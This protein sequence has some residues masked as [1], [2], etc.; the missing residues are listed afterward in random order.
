MILVL[1]TRRVE[2]AG[3]DVQMSIAIVTRSLVLAQNVQSG[4]SAVGNEWAHCKTSQ[5]VTATKKVSEVR[6]TFI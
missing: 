4:K 1:K 3:V 6:I 5:T 2:T